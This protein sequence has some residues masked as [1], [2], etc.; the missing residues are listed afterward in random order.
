MR[1]DFNLIVEEVPAGTAASY[2]VEALA[3]ALVGPT[4]TKVSERPLRATSSYPAALSVW[5]L[6]AAINSSGI[7]IYLL[8]GFSDPDLPLETQQL[9]QQLAWRIS[10]NLVYRRR[11]RLVLVDY[12]ASLPSVYSARELLDDVPSATQVS[13]DDL[14]TCLASHYADLATR[15]QLPEPGLSD[16]RTVASTLIAGAPVDS[17]KRL[18]QLND[19]LRLL[20]EDDLQKAGLA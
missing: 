3:D 8:D 18:E 15:A 7:W 5:I 2:P 14:A 16:L 20:R 9:V 11:V 1:D 4:E 6:N 17:S 13:P 19:K 12:P 10:N